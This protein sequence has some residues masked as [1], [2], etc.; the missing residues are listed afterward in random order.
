[1]IGKRRTDDPSVAGNRS[2]RRGW[3]WYGQSPVRSDHWPPTALAL[4]ENRFPERARCGLPSLDD[5]Q[6]SIGNARGAEPILFVGIED[7]GGNLQ[8]FEELRVRPLPLIDLALGRLA[9]AE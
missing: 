2:Q 6:P 8:A 1:M 9:G 4:A 3:P 5:D 7:P